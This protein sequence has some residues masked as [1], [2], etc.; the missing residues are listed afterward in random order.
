MS[1]EKERRAGGPRVPLHT[2]VEIGAGEG[3]SAAFEAEAIDVTTAGMHLKTAYLP[4][5]GEPLVC[6]FEGGGTEVVVQG[7]VA[8]RTED[9]YG[10]D[11]GVR[12][13]EMDQE[14]LDALRAIAG[15][16]IEGEDES[17]SEGESDDEPVRA[18]PVV[19]RGTRVR[20][21]IEG[22]GSPMKAR[23]RE[24]TQHEVLV[25]SNLEFLRVGRN[26]DLENV[27]AESNRPARIER[28]SVEVEPTS[29]VPQLI[30]ALRYLDVS[31]EEPAAM[32]TQYAGDETDEEQ[33]EGAYV[34]GDGEDEAESKP[35]AGAAVWTK[36]KKVGP[37]F[38]VLGAFAQRWGVKAKDAVGDAVVVVKKKAAQKV[39]ERK[40][41][42]APRRTTAPPP[43]GGY[44]S[45]GLRKQSGEESEETVP[46]NTEASLKK[47]L[48]KRTAMIAVVTLLVLIV[49]GGFARAAFQSDPDEVA[50]AD[51][52]ASAEVEDQGDA[53]IVPGSMGTDTASAS[54]VANVPLFGPKPMST[55]AP[56][57]PM[58]AIPVPA[59]GNAALPPGDEGSAGSDEGA[60]EGAAEGAAEGADEGAEEGSDSE[61]ASATAAVDDSEGDDEDAE[62][63]A[64]PAKQTAKSSKKTAKTDAPKSFG[65]G[66]VSNPVVLTL[67]MNRKIKDIRGVAQSDGFAIDVI[68]ARSAEPAAGLRRQDSRIAVSKVVNR[69]SNSQLSIRFKGATPAYRVQASGS[70]L[71]ILIDGDK[72]TASTQSDRGKKRR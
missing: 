7:E 51:E 39:E 65:R 54:L 58:A 47:H 30:V 23:V 40:A 26:I 28:I 34:Q 69:G 18:S 67:R 38:A 55:A 36:V 12:F 1:V 14:S 56:M 41:A 44:R 52:A 22:L 2:L 31:E 45:A 3:G 42:A 71:R 32:E 68:G 49:G 27:D 25:G 6:R 61:A 13:L 46:V 70:T 20:L 50:A 53:P 5:V 9:S 63:E 37:K 15:E 11:F 64:K 72:K 19:G 21:H 59:V 17:E 16:E 24:G 29:R 66:R 10:G 62:P 8:W 33:D 60:E 48:N 57:A 35:G 4:E 43:K